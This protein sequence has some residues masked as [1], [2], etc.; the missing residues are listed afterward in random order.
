MCAIS[1]R[2]MAATGSIDQWV[3]HTHEVLE[4]I[5]DMRFAMESVESNCRGYVLTG[6]ASYLNSYRASVARVEQDQAD[7]DHL[8]L[9]NPVQQRQLP[10]LNALTAEK[11]RHVEMII[12]LRQDQGLPATVAM[13][14][15]GKGQRLM[16]EFQA[17]T[18]T[19]QSEELRLLVIRNESARRHLIE[20]RFALIFGCLLGLLV[21][22]AAGWSA[23]RDSSKQEDAS[24]R[25]DVKEESDARYRG[26][27]EAAPDAM[28]VV[29]QE[30]E[31]VLLNLQA[32]K[33][34]GYHR[35][36]LLGQ[37]VTNIIPEGFAE[38]II[39]DDLR[40]IADALAQQIGTGIELNALRKDGSVF[41]IDHAQS[42][43]ECRWHSGDGGHS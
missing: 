29:N 9:D 31:I 35:D 3:R 23:R 2:E 43:G 11:I 28:V 41:P 20:T 24:L 33:Q 37:R 30:G 8:T 14:Q 5:Q 19:L 40:S 6:D 13:M 38:R 32:E 4:K 39:A 26:L 27:L 34:F 16:L 21:A 42:A 25:E 22:A 10:A 18:D 12:H 15:S 1:Y 7:F 36:E 17:L